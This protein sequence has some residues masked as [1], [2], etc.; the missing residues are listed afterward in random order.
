MDL[1]NNI[2]VLPRNCLN[3]LVFL[4]GTPEVSPSERE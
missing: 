1:G 2:T 3:T 4:R